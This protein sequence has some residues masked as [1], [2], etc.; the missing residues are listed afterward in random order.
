L[1]SSVATRHA[2][3]PRVE[4]LYFD[5][6]PSHR[7]L[8]PRL[9]RIMRELGMDAQ[10]LAL[11]RIDSP[12]A[13]QAARFLGSPSVRVDDIDVEPGAAGRDD[14]GLRCRLYDV[15]GR[16]TGIPSDTWLRVALAR[17]G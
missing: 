8:L 3:H 16:R 17:A 9:R 2:T 13:A 5:G 11:R 7:A 12:E 15:D 14:F 10:S 1:S 6:C 4:I